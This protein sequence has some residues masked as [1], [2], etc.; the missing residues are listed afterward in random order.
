M[1]T[2]AIANQKGGVGKTTTSVN[3]AAA[4]IKYGRKVLLVDLDP[5]ATATRFLLDKYGQDGTTIY[6]VLFQRISL[7]ECIQRSKAGIPIVPSNFRLASLDMDLNNELN[8]EN[9][10]AMALEETGGYDYVLVDCPTHL[11]FANINAFA[12]AQKVL[13]PIECAPEAWEAVPYLME[14][15]RKIIKQLNHPLRVYA[16]PTFLDRTNI[17]KDIHEEILKHFESYT[18]SPIAKNVKL[19]EAF[20]ARTPVIQYDPTASGAMDYLRT[21]KEII[22]ESE[23]TEVRRNQEGRGNRSRN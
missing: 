18:L 11:G 17:A 21:A 3:L 5:Q 16:L 4:L 1:I 7:A 19:K 14:T 22:S 9:R 12:A 8:R 23:E 6:D 13:I 15:L 10:L 2:I 20:N